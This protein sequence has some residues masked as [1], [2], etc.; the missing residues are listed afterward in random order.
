M[1]ASLAPDPITVNGNACACQCGVLAL[2]G[3]LSDGKCAIGLALVRVDA[4]RGGPGAV[5]SAHTLPAAEL[6]YNNAS[7]AYMPCNQVAYDSFS[8]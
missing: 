4:G 2:E 1:S 8:G 7:P 6:A 5:L 3:G